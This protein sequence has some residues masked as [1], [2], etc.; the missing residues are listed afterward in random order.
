MRDRVLAE[1]LRDYTD[2]LEVFTADASP[3]E[4][5]T[6]Q[7]EFARLHL[8]RAANVEGMNRS[9]YVTELQQG[10]VCMDAA[11]TLL[12]QETF[13]DIWTEAEHTATDLE[14][15]LRVLGVPATIMMATSS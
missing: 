14:T 15:K 4:W 8:L 7:F 13:P 3:I 5:A 10:K 1:A 11:F 12:N 2:A 6:A 9:A